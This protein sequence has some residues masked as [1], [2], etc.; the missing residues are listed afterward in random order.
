MHFIERKSEFLL[1]Q[2]K[3]SSPN[4]SVFDSIL[5][6]AINKEQNTIKIVKYHSFEDSVLQKSHLTLFL[7]FTIDSKQQILMYGRSLLSFLLTIVQCF[8]SNEI[9][10]C[11]AG[12]YTTSVVLHSGLKITFIIGIF[13]CM[14]EYRIFGQVGQ[15]PN[16][17]KAPIIV[18]FLVIFGNFLIFISKK[19]C[20]QH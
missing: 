1:Q 16:T 19:L 14:T 17:E 7:A 4:F 3:E 18:L 6:E 20:L 10:F 2:E 12:T 9:L 15:I 11:E 5:Y 8:L 13:Q